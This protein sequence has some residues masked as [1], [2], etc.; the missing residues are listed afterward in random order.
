MQNKQ[1]EAVFALTLCVSSS[2]LVLFSDIS[3]L[4]FSY[5]KELPAEPQKKV[6]VFSKVEQ[7]S[8]YKET[9]LH[10]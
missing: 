9:E 4:I 7:H 10:V 8:P 1:E 2:D 5:C 3:R 6:K